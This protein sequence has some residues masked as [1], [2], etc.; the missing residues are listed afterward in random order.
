[1][2][3]KIRWRF[4]SAEEVVTFF[5]IAGAV[6]LIVLTLL[7]IPSCVEIYYEG[8]FNLSQM[9]HPL[10]NKSPVKVRP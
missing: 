7:V 5:G 9:S 8:I 2:K 1:V 3:R 4:P 6:F 10:G